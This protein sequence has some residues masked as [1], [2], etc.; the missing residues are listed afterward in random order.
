MQ[1][2]VLRSNC[3]FVVVSGSGGSGKS[4]CIS[5]LN[6]YDVRN[7]NKFSATYLRRNIG[8]FFTDG[9]IASMMKEIY[10]LRSDKDKGAKR[11]TIGEILTSPQTMG[12]Y[13]DN[14]ATLRFKH[15]ADERKEALEPS[16]KGIQSNRF[17]F[18]E[19]DQFK[20]STIFYV[21]T[22]MRGK[23]KGKR[24][25][26]IVQNPEREC[27]IRQ[28]CG[29][30]QYG[31]GWIADNGE[32]IEERNGTVMY[33]HIVEGDINKVYWGKTKKEVYEKCKNIIDVYVERTKK[34]GSTYESFIQSCVFFHLETIS[35][36][37]MLKENPDYLGSLAMSS[38]AASMFKANWN[39][40]KFDDKEEKDNLPILNY[41]NLSAMFRNEP[42]VN[43]KLR[44]VV[45]PA[46]EGVDNFTIMAF[47]GFH[48]FD[49]WY[50]QK[51]P[52]QEAPNRITD[53]MRKHGATNKDLIIDGNGFEYI[54][55]LFPGAY[56][57]HGT[58]KTSNKGKE[59]NRLRD[60]A[61]YVMCQMVDRGLITFDPELENIPYKHQKNIK[62][63][64]TLFLQILEEARCYVFEEDDYGKKKLLN[65]SKQSSIIGGKS[66]DIT[67]LMVML[68]GGTIYD[69]YL[70]LAN[71][72]KKFD[73]KE[74]LKSISNDPQTNALPNQ[75]K[76]KTKNIANILTKKFGW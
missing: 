75:E 38:G 15:I 60:E 66:S 71:K 61:A 49:F 23:G 59:F 11:V 6:S 50:E 20:A 70:E 3:D 8:D 51:T 36:E 29:C 57:Y 74:A 58:Y 34:V 68:C 72:K 19:A 16:F 73:A 37:S 14:G 67:D 13:F 46:R 45:D 24:Q 39:Y 69:C 10:P 35:N 28:F 41:G 62:K 56:F 22:R 42:N 55:H 32:V 9:G 18:D 17:I 48:A 52:P 33:F 21:P 53:F 40:S 27:F 1:L 65:K 64:N 7:N 12:V 5:M 76:K 30:G 47:Q 2:R 25:I 43:N 44:I 4:F 26:Y 63:S 54:K 31:G